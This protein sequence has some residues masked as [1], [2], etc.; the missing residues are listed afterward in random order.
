[1]R[2]EPSRIAGVRPIRW[3]VA[4]VL[5]L[6]A[7]TEGNGR[8]LEPPK[9]APPQTLAPEP[10]APPAPV[11]TGPFQLI[12]PWPDGG[13][14]NQRHTCSGDDI[15]PALTWRNAPAGTTE[16]AITAVDLDASG[17]VHWI[18]YGIDPARLSIVE[19]EQPAPGIQWTN[20]AGSIGWV[21]PCPPVGETHLYQVTIHALAAPLD[22]PADT[23]PTEVISMLNLLAIDQ[24]SV[25]GTFMREQ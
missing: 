18:V 1:M 19:D 11:A 5:L 2:S 12:A 25:S 17:Y 16:V 20:T 21:G 6:S 15:A 13:Q 10:T 22:V 23:E 8:T 7:C 3:L 9:F 24:G 14:I 4:A